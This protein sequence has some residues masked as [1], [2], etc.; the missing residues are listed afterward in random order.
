MKEQE[1][2]RAFAQKSKKKPIKTKEN[3]KVS[4]ALIG[5][6]KVHKQLT[7]I[8]IT[9]FVEQAIQDKLSKTK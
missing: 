2:Y 1:P 3:V 4:I 6:L 9:A 8:T 7:G 5:Q